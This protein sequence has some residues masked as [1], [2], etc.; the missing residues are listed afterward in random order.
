MYADFSYYQNKYYGEVI[1][2][3][4]DWEKHEA[5][6]RRVIDK[7]TMKRCIN[8]A[9]QRVEVKDAVCA[10]ADT[11][12]KYSQIKENLKGIKQ[13]NTSGYSVTYKDDADETMRIEQKAESKARYFLEGTGLLYRGRYKHDH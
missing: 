4:N 11:L 10:A 12:A 13:E 3:E 2:T 5:Q 8:V 9:D 7:I 1:K 6:A